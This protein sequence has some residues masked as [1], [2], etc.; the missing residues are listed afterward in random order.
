MKASTDPDTTVLRRLL[1]GGPALSLYFGL[2]PP[3]E[4]ETVSDRWRSTL[5]RLA[6]HGAGTAACDALTRSVEA[7]LPGP[8][9]PS[10]SAPPS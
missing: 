8:G 7:A 4:A 5:N 3:A 9:V 6:R 10:R 1:T 2:P